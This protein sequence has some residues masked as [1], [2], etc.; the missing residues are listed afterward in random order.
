[1]N[2]YRVA[3]ALWLAGA[4]CCTAGCVTQVE[5]DAIARANLQLQ[6]RVAAAQAERVKSRTQ[7]TMLR[8]EVMQAR[9]AAQEARDQVQTL[10]QQNQTLQTHLDIQAEQLR[11]ARGQAAQS[12]P[13]DVSQ[14]TLD[15]LLLQID[16]LRLQ[17]ADLRRENGRLRR[18]LSQYEP[19][20]PPGATTQAAS[21]P[22]SSR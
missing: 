20:D 21:Q 1:M 7:T 22:A 2:R 11:G 13:A 8:Q 16:Q 3:I 9:L 18:R 15:R 14:E 19:V 4:L 17:T 5:H 12:Q 10:S 6:D